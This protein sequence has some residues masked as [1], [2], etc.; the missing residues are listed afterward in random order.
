MDRD[1]GIT[2]AGQHCAGCEH[3]RAIWYF[4]KRGE[5]QG[6]ACYFLLDTGHRRGGTIEDCTKK[7]IM[8]RASA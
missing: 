4:G 6:K 5:T 7:T 8:G 2:S 1:N 3:W